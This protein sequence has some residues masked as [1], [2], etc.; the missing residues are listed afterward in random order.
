[1]AH[2]LGHLHAGHLRRRWLIMPGLFTPF[3]GSAYS[4]ACEFTSDRYGIAATRE[5]ERALDGLV[6][7]AAGGRQAGLVN[8]RA[9]VAQTGDLKGF[10]MHLGQ[11]LSTHPPI[12]HRLGVL[13]ANLAS[14]RVQSRGGVLAAAIL[15][16]FGLFMPVLGGLGLM[17]FYR[18]MKAQVADTEQ[19]QMQQQAA[20]EALME[21]QGEA[22][23]EPEA[24]PEAERSPE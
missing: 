18:T 11:W 5:R 6:I 1:V 15:I 23:A 2:E 24:E 17:S 4:R 12:A 7:L 13:D 21:N 16:V 8:R 20:F 19:A 22:E 3:L 14:A 10:W 9:L